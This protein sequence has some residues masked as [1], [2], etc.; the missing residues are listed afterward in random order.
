MHSRKTVVV[1]QAK[2]RDATVSFSD[3]TEIALAAFIIPKDYNGTSAMENRLLSMLN[4]LLNNSIDK[5]WN[6]VEFENGFI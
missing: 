1:S 3:L 5:E 4:I 2:L 6:Y